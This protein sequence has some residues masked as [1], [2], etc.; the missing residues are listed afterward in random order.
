MSILTI[1][2]DTLTDIADAIRAKTGKS[3]EMTPLEMPDEI[4]SISGGGGG[5]DD[6][7]YIEGVE[8]GTV[9]FK[10]NRTVD[11]VDLQYSTDKTN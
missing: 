7:F 11:D 9:K 8:A 10:S 6:Y 3:D 1:Q 2:E 4:A 5:S